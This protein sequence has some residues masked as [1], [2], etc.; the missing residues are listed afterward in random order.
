METLTV[1]RRD[2][3]A[4]RRVPNFRMSGPQFIVDAWG[5][6]NAPPRELLYKGPCVTCRRRCYE[7]TDG[8]NDPRGIIG[9]N[10]AGASVRY[11]PNGGG[12]LKERV[13]CFE[14]N[15]TESTYNRFVSF[16]RGL[17]AGGAVLAPNDAAGDWKWLV[18]KV[19]AEKAQV[20]P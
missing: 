9:D 12:A 17:L 14:C 3:R 11:T 2:S 10:G 7:F 19:N 5:G 20:T 8:S 13:Q 4:P 1:K 6:A 16:V 15:N 18:D